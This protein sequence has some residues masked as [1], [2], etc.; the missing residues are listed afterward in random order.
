MSDELLQT[1]LPAMNVAV[2]RRADDGSFSP[3]APSPPW[4][5]RLADV[6]FPFLGH[7]LDEANAFWCSG[8]LGSR[9]YGPVAETNADGG[10]FHYRIQ[11]LT[12]G[13]GT[14]FLIFELDRGSD[15]IRDTL[16]TARD[17]AL[18]REQAQTRQ[19]QVLVEIEQ[20]IAEMQHLLGRVSSKAPG[21]TE[22][23]LIEALNAKCR[24][25]LEN[26]DSLAPGDHPARKDS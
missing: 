2:F 26:V 15:R 16:Q 19:R 4:F 20:R 6:T 1:L 9:E 13:D 24:A 21:S 18:A 5:S 7:I 12:A 11:A 22:R 25:V 17:Q 14:H 23:G 8:A 3:V 10:E